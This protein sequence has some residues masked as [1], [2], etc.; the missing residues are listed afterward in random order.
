MEKTDQ[1]L[2]TWAVVELFGHQKIAGKLSEH[3]LGAAVMVRVT[4]PKTEFHP[5]Y[6][7]LLN[8]SAIYA[9]NPMEESL[10][11]TFAQRLNLSPIMPYEASA[12]LSKLI[13]EKVQQRL[14][15]NNP[16]SNDFDN[17]DFPDNDE[18]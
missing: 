1:K 15:P 18:D 4:V 14:N 12:M 2:D 10:V 9:I 3:N 17:N 5:E 7:R 16:E 8:P 13:E 6:D 11:R